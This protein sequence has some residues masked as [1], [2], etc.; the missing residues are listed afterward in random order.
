[1]AAI[2]VGAFNLIKAVVE[3]GDRMG[4]AR[5]SLQFVAAL[6]AA[7]LFAVVWGAAFRFRR[8]I[9]GLLVVTCVA[10]VIGAFIV[11]GRAPAGPQTE[12]P[13]PTTSQPTL[14]ELTT[15]STSVEPDG[16]GEPA[17]VTVGPADVEICVVYWCNGEVRSLITGEVDPTQI[18]YK[19]RPKIINTDPDHPLNI[20]LTAPSP[21]RLIVDS[22]MLPQHWEPP[23]V[24]AANGDT[25]LPF[26][27]DGHQYWAVPPNAN[28]E[29]YQVGDW[30][31][32]FATIWD[33]TE[34]APSLVYFK[35][36]R[37]SEDGVTNTQEADLVFQVPK[38]AD[39]S[40][41]HIIGLAYVSITAD[42]TAVSRAMD[43]WPWPDPV[44]P[45]SF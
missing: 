41:P 12:S 11:P 38:N 9:A 35:K 29:A 28:H 23:P 32:G 39:G 4:V 2:L 33:D 42:N 13:T 22:T 40:D 19:I 45:N 44:Q 17:A 30:W 18:Q 20:A 14:P 8:T 5:V 25:V 31:S 36:L 26:L 7:G 37:L 21:L 6:A 34:I 10:A 15:P 1:M 3:W 16:C 27:R 24:T 43:P